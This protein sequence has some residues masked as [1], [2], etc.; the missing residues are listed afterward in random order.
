[1]MTTTT[2]SEPD[3]ATIISRYSDVT[4]RLKRSHELLGEE[5]SRLRDELEE[6][7]RA[8]G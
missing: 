2:V 8:P 5:V 4:E 7:N 1:M 6:K 3:L